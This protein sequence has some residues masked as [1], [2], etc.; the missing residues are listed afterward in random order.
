MLA[1]G[2]PETRLAYLRRGA[3][4]VLDTRY[5]GG[6]RGTGSHDVSAEAAYVPREWT[7]SPADA[8]TLGR[9]IGRIPIICTMAAGFAAQTL[10]LAQ[11]ALD[12]LIALA[13][14]KPQVESGPA[15]RDRPALQAALPLQTA[16]L[17][18]AR[19]HLV[20]RT[21]ELWRAVE[22][23][24]T[25][26]LRP[27]SALWAAAHH[28]VGAA[29]ETLDRSYA[30]AGTTALYTDCPLERAHRDLH[31]ML[32]HV[33]AQTSWLED[34]GKVTLGLAPALPLYAI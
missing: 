34:A 27:I 23:E 31:A 22:S 13:K 33:V 7:I 8:P 32:R 1:P 24:E 11:A 5:V 21:T 28:A 2:V 20:R 30:A 17:E 25:D 3:L 19:S 26:L 12:T 29:K 16:A 10:G 9:P 4:Q 18:A 14:T 15:L 6:L